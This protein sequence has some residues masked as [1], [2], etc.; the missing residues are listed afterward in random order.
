[1]THQHRTGLLLVL[2]LLLTA[3]CGQKGSLYLPDDPEHRESRLSPA[4]QQ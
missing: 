3:G 4:G 2:T 1:M